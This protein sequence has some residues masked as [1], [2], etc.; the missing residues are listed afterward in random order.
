LLLRDIS[1]SIHLYGGSDLSDEPPKERSYSTH[2][3]REGKGKNQMVC[4]DALGGK[5]RDHSVCVVLEL[6]K[7]TCIFQ[8]FNG[9]APLMSMK[10]FTIH[11]I[12][13]FDRLTTSQIN[14]MM[15]QYSSAEQP[16]RTCAPMLAIRMVE[17]HKNEG[18]LRVS[19]LPIKFNID[20]DTMEFLEDFLQEVRTRVEIPSEVSAAVATRPVL[21]VPATIRSSSATD[22]LKNTPSYSSINRDT[23]LNL[24]V[25]MPQNAPPSP[26]YDLSYLENCTKSV[27]AIKRSG[28]AFDAPLTALAVSTGNLFGTKSR[29]PQHSTTL[30]GPASQAIGPGSSGSGSADFMRA[31]ST[32]SEMLAD[33]LHLVGDWSSSSEIKICD[34]EMGPISAV[35]KML[36]GASMHDSFHPD[37]MATDDDKAH[38][39]FLVSEELI[40]TS[41]KIEACLNDDD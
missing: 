3:Y 23:P 32:E 28:S 37:M 2:E 19:M 6:K 24:D 7:I 4:A 22:S 27:P 35:D 15:Y 30:E 8:H 14:E 38:D 21:E 29:S 11:D 34:M 9:D 25:L 39:D 26:V 18:K 33:N 20:Q 10:L 41:G 17:S 12:T 40:D 13:L 5:Y 36:M 16:R 1:V 31:T